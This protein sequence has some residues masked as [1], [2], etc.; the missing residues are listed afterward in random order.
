MK[1]ASFLVLISIL[2]S[3]AYSGFGADR[4]VQPLSLG[5]ALELA[6]TSNYQV[7][8]ARS[9]LKEADGRNLESWQAFVPKLDVGGSFIRSNDPV[10]VFG[11]KLKQG[12]FTM[13]DFELDRLN[14]PDP[15]SNWATTI[16]LQQPLINVDAFYGKSAAG[17]AE[18][19]G[20]HGLA[21]AEEAVALE[22]EKAYYG[23]ILSHSHLR[24]IDDA[25]KSAQTLH[26]EVEASHQRGLVSE[27]DLLASQVRL[28]EMEEQQLTARLN[29][30]NSNDYLK[31][32]LGMETAVDIV[33]TDSLLVTEADFQIEELPPDTIPVNRHDLLA[34]SFADKAASRELSMRRSEWIPRLNAFGGLEWNS[35]EFL[36]DTQS[37]W[38]FGFQLEWSLLD[39]LGNWG[40]SRQAGAKSAAA[41]VKYREAEAKSRMEVRQ[42]HRALLTAR[43]RMR[44]A[45]KAVV[46]SR[47]SLRITEARFQEGLE[48]VSDVLHR[49][50]A[51]TGARLR[52]QRAQHDFK[53]A[54]SELDFYLG[55][56]SKSLSMVDMPA[57]DSVEQ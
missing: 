4:V 12:V 14:H 40:R 3:L 39:G 30:S 11:T 28:A 57:T 17:L 35:A 37:N 24:T 36:Q 1:P 22:V 23:L 32:I 9:Q 48:R 6:K 49:E 5:E 50:A 54:Q 45:E 38:I 8:I 52:L 53:V 16:Q 13:E 47:E 33:P 31:F 43:E 2:L 10:F 29:I 25:V 15:I 42:A 19:A 41:R 21:R 18:R 20:E 27:A 26:H 7:L 56:P 51:Y 55:A 46:H 44:V 34:L